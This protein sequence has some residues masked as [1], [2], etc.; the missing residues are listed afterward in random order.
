MKI[1][2]TL[3]VALL[4]SLGF[5]KAPEWDA[6]KLDAKLRQVPERVEPDKVDSKFKAL[7][8][9]LEKMGVDDTIEFD[10]AKTAPVVEGQAE[11]KPKSKSAKSA[12]AKAAPAKKPAKEAKAKPAKKEKK[13]KPAKKER[14]TDEF[15]FTA[16]T[17][18]SK[19]MQALKGGAT[20]PDEVAKIVGVSVD[21]AEG[22]LR[23]LSRATKFIDVQ[24]RVDYL[25]K[26]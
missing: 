14:E 20:T 21:Q 9:Q 18:R 17:M 11:E 25:L 26:K 4:V 15:G 2:H 8:A 22:R 23:Y 13:E 6:A 5:E 19:V 1:N 3:A 12:K 24:R 16:G 10:G 7:Y